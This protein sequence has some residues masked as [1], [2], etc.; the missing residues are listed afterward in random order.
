[1]VASVLFG[2]TEI[3]LEYCRERH[4]AGIGV[5]KRRGFY[6]GRTKGTFNA[7]PRR[8]AELYVRGFLPKEIAAAMKVSERTVYRYLNNPRRSF[9]KEGNRR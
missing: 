2:L 1:M 8:A 3:E 6:R 7:T 5:A 9:A 4:A